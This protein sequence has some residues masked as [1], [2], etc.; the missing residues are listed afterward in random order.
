MNTNPHEFGRSI[1]YT[2]PPTVRR[3]L[4]SDTLYRVILEPLGSG[5][6]SGLALDC[7]QRS[8]AQDPWKNVR[9]TRFV[10]IRSPFYE[11]ADYL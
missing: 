2:S 4:A 7:L 11:F 10:F 6:T 5:K 9:R 3:L 1:T 8:C